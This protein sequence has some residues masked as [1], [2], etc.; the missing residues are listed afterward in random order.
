MLRNKEEFKNT[1][2]D[3]LKAMLEESQQELD[4]ST[5]ELEMLEPKEKEMQEAPPIEEEAPADEGLQ[6]DE[7]GMGM[8][9]EKVEQMTSVLV[10]A[11]LLAE[12]SI[13][14]SPSLISE[15]QSIADQID[16]GLYDLSQPDQ[17]EEFIDGINSGTISP[18][19][20]D[21]SGDDQPSGELGEGPSVGLDG[22]AAGVPDP[23]F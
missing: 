20:R 9:P 12:I 13:E 4:E 8:T 11:G 23:I 6:M 17:L 21:T 2:L 16:P 18:V 14:L 22:G 1:S 19:I 3:D 5:K 7:F 10:E 15:L